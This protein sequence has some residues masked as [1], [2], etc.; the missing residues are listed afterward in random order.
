MFV[1]MY[2]Y[3]EKPVCNS[4]FLYSFCCPVFQELGLRVHV[5][6]ENTPEEPEPDNFLKTLYFPPLV[7]G[8]VLVLV[9]VVV[10]LT[11]KCRYQPIN[12]RKQ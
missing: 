7:A 6:E 8:A 5:T 10:V 3:M 11:L 2:V 12:D 1:C 9:V 4:K